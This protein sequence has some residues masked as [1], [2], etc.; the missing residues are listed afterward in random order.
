[1]DAK[2]KELLEQMAGGIIIFEP[3]RR[4]SRELTEFQETARLLLLMEQQG[5]IHHCYPTE[6]E[7]AG[8]NYFDRM[9]IPRG[10]TPA[11]EAALRSAR[12]R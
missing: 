9:Y 3:L 6:F 5:L 2:T 10:L 11:G 8:A 12:G 7:I 4:T 1:M